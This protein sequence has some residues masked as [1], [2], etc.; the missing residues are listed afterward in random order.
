MFGAQISADY[1]FNKYCANPSMQEWE[2]KELLFSLVGKLE[3]EEVKSI[4]EE[5]IRQND[6]VSI[7]KDNFLNWF[8]YDE[9]EKEF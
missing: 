8:G 9:L 1:I 5:L 6:G 4:W 7:S 3:A 2:F